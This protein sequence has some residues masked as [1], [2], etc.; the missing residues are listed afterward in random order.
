MLEWLPWTLTSGYRSGYF[1]VR[2]IS[3]MASYWIDICTVRP[4]FQRYCRANYE[5]QQAFN[6]NFSL[7]SVNKLYSRICNLNAIHASTSTTSSKHKV[8]YRSNSFIWSY[9]VD[10]LVFRPAGTIAYKKVVAYKQTG[11]D[12]DEKVDNIFTFIDGNI[13]FY[14][15]YLS[16]W[17]VGAIT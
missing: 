14:I 4:R 10:F 9:H 8:R 12:L 3:V 11:V 6:P 5:P 13:C 7:V 15:V 2:I 17:R 1:G 16:F